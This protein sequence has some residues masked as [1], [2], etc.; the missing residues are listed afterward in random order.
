M[1]GKILLIVG[2][3]GVGKS[4]LGVTLAK[5]F[6]GEIINADS[7]QVYC[8]LDIGTAKPSEEFFRQVPHHL[9]DFLS[10]KEIWSAS[11]FQEAAD[12]AIQSIQKNNHLPI[13]VGGTGLYVR[14]LL[15]GLFEGPAA[16]AMIRQELALLDN[17]T[18]HNEL[19]KID[20][21]AARALHPN[22]R[23]RLVRAI[24]VYRLTGKTI[25]AHQDAHQF[26]KPRYDYLKIGIT[27][28]RALMYEKINERVDHMVG[29]GLEAEARQLWQKWGEQSIWG[30][31]IGYQ[32]WLPYFKNLC[33]KDM[34]IEKIKQHSRNFAKRQM[35]WF[36]E[37]KDIT[38]LPQDAEKIGKMIADFLQAKARN[39]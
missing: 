36:G 35:T 13:V 15:F 18:L 20:P 23:V 33:S 14:A 4:E 39:L 31:S 17:A 32:E 37:E 11:S 16:D 1:S 38:W 30:E 19:K 26:K 21:I 34:V 9:F 22:D 24:E 8:E 27:M 5:K 25:S 10:P 7:R 3:T 2:P 12:K 6:A 28:E 29:L